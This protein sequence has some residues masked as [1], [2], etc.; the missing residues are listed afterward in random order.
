MDFGRFSWK[1]FHEGFTAH[2][3]HVDDGFAVS[4]VRSVSL[5]HKHILHDVVVVSIDSN[6]YSPTSKVLFLS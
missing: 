4:F 3:I 5:S 6:I 2:L 1:F